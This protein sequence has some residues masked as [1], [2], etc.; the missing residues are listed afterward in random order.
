M[1]L[2][3]RVL[4]DVV[5]RRQKAFNQVELIEKVTKDYIGILSDRLVSIALDWVTQPDRV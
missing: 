1:E 2:Q 3:F 5:L 4:K